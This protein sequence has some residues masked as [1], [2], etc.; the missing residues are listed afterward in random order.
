MAK[1]LSHIVAPLRHYLNQRFS[2]HWR[3]NKQISLADTSDLPAPLFVAFM[4]GDAIVKSAFFDQLDKKHIYNPDSQQHSWIQLIG[5][6]RAIEEVIEH[7]GAAQFFYLDN[8]H[9]YRE[10]C[11]NA[12]CIIV[13]DAALNHSP[14]LDTLTKG[15]VDHYLPT[16]YPN[17]AKPKTPEQFQKDIA[18]LLARQWQLRTEIK[19]SFTTSATSVEFSL[20]VKVP[21]HKTL[22]LLTLTGEKLKPT[23]LKAYKQCILRLEQGT[24]P[25]PK[26]LTKRKKDV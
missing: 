21:Q 5:N 11:Y 3:L 16:L 9:R 2:A 18:Q 14:L 10:Q 26:P 1:H 19:E 25:P 24:M 23:R 6:G 12:F 7:S 13:W 22:T 15:L 4:R 17:K 8:Q 20:L